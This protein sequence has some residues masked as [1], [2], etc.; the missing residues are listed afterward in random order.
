LY[1]NIKKSK[2]YVTIRKTFLNDVKNLK[3]FLQGAET[4]HINEETTK[5]FEE[6]ICK[7]VE[8]TLNNKDVKLEIQVKIEKGQKKL[9]DSITLQLKNENAE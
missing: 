5:R 9:M 7:K 3:R 6:E 8:D 1:K 2:G 4:K